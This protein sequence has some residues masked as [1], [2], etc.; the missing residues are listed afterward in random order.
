MADIKKTFETLSNMYMDQVKK[1]DEKG[2][3]D[4]FKKA[5]EI[6][7]EDIND[8]VEDFTFTDIEYF[9][10]YFIFGTGTNSIVH[11]RVKE[12]PGWKFGVWWDEP[13]EDDR[14]SGSFFAQF[15]ETIDKFKPSHSTI[16]ETFT[17]YDMTPD[18]YDT[19]EIRE[20]LN[21]IKNEPELAFCRDYCGYDYNKMYLSREEAK[22]KY[23][24]YRTRKD[25]ETELT[26]KYDTKI[27]NWVRENILPVF[28]DAT[29]EDLG[30]N[31]S[32]RYDVFAP[33]NKNTDI[34]DEPGCYGWYSDEPDEE[35]KKLM[36]EF[37]ELIAEAQKAFEEIDSWYFSPIH[38]SITF[39][40]KEEE[41]NANS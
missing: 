38:E 36:N 26:E 25:K 6:F 10:G 28:T 5:T 32:P 40:N 19:H 39:Y 3:A 33:F 27:L 9:D 29:I 4:L 22:E 16:T 41:E 8:K 1:I 21:F 20:I 23:D 34:V 11:F 13:E 2:Y 31:W 37:D 14:I 17:I 30:R 7:F 24:D 12:C 18:K 15:E 35:E